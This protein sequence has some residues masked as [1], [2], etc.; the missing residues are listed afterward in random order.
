MLRVR[1]STVEGDEVRR[2][3][4]RSGMNLAVLMVRH[5][6]LRM[7]TRDRELCGNVP[8]EG[9]FRFQIDGTL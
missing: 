5:H 6:L 1:Y 2:Q 3:F 8:I 9:V 7:Y 4:F